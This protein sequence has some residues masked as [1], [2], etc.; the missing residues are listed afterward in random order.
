MTARERYDDMIRTV[1]GGEL[2][3]QGFKRSRNRFSRWRNEGW[4]I[5]DFQASQWGDRDGVRFTINL[6][7]AV[8]GL[9][10]LTPW[11]EKK[12]PPED[13]AH[14][15]QRV[16]ELID[17]RDRW[18]RFDATTDATALADELLAVLRRV[19]MPW[20]DA[21]SELEQVLE[22]ISRSPEDLGWHDLR[23]LPGLLAES[24]HKDAAEAVEAEAE[25]RGQAAGV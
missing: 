5:I 24:G 12:A 1:V 6:G 15:R 18:W 19:G 13:A 20:L 9:P 22:L 23:V 7:S 8:A 16:G 17:G 11:D 2:K 4:Q 25:R 21:R 10:K 14:L 3:R